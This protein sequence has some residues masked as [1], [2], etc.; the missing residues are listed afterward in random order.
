MDHHDRH[1]RV[2]VDTNVCVGSGTCAMMDPEHF[3]LVD[4]KAHVVTEEV[5]LTEELD[6]AVLDCPVQA[7]RLR[8]A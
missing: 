4:G 8:D 3:R 2:D 5:T 7:L 6:D 1:V